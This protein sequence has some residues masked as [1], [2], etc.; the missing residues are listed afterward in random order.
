M[1]DGREVKLKM[2]KT[3]EHVGTACEMRV[4]SP[5]D[6]LHPMLSKAQSKLE[7]TQLSGC[8]HHGTQ[9]SVA[10]ESLRYPGV[11]LGKAAWPGVVLEPI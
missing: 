1:A 7:A 9:L 4:V 10:R 5:Q 3:L 11:L 2:W 6:F 8:E